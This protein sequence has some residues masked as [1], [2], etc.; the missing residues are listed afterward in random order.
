MARAYKSNALRKWREQPL[1]DRLE[2]RLFATEM[3]V[4]GA[5][6]GSGEL[7]DAVHAGAFVTFITKRGGRGIQNDVPFDAKP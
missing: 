6:R 5:F 2:K 3:V 7:R 1:H 4:D